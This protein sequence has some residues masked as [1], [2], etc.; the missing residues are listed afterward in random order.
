M[1]LNR[2]LTATILLMPITVLAQ[3]KDS[4]AIS[5]ILKFQAELNAEFANAEESPLTE[6]DFATFT[7]LPF[8]PIDTAFYVVANF[9]RATDAQPFEMKT[10]TARRPVYQLYGTATFTLKGQ[11]FQLQ[12][13]QNLKLRESEEYRDYLFLPFTDL[14][15]GNGSY[16]GGRFID[17]KIPA[18][19]TIIIDFN[20]AY[21]PL[22]AYNAKY[23]CPIPPAE[24][25]LDVAITAGVQYKH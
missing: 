18:G 21:N 17:L 15:C 22:C 6:E 3:T 9:A 12:I 8:Y 2:L 7:G 13:F 19:D 4:T 24:N 25:A 10:T 14:T 16:P 20:K 23:S 11:T 5:S 1:K